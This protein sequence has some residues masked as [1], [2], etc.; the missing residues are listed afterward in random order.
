M[1]K[2][3]GLY[4]ALFFINASLIA[5]TETKNITPFTNLLLKYERF[6]LS[7]KGSLF[8]QGST[9]KGVGTD[10][11]YQFF[12]YD[13][14]A[15][16]NITPPVTYGL[17]DLADISSSL[18]SVFYIL[19][20]ANNTFEKNTAFSWSRRW[21]WS[22]LQA[23]KAGVAT[24]MV[25]DRDQRCVILG[26]IYAS[27]P[28]Y[29]AKLVTTDTWEPLIHKN[30]PA[31]L[32][33][34][35][36][37][38]T[39]TKALVDRKNNIYIS[40][41]NTKEDK[42]ILATW[43]GK[44]WKLISDLLPGAM[45]DMVLD[46]DAN[47]YVSGSSKNE[48]NE[49]YI[50]KW[51]G[52]KWSFIPAPPEAKFKGDM[53]RTLAIGDN[54]ELLTGGR[55]KKE[56][57]NIILKWNGNDWEEYG[58]VPGFVNAMSF[59]NGQ[60]FA[61]V[62]GKEAG[63]YLVPEGG[64][65]TAASTEA[66]AA[67]MDKK[68]QEVLDLYTAY[69][70]QYPQAIAKLPAMIK[71]WRNQATRTSSLEQSTK[72]GTEVMHILG[73]IYTFASKL[74]DLKLGDGDNKLHGALKSAVTAEMYAF[75]NLK[76]LM[77]LYQNQYTNDTEFDKWWKGYE[78][79]ENKAVLAFKKATDLIPL[80]EKENGVKQI[81]YEGSKEDYRAFCEAF[82]KVAKE[83]QAYYSIKFYAMGQG[84][85]NTPVSY[86][87]DQNIP[88]SILNKVQKADG[89]ITWSAL[90]NGNKDELLGKKAFLDVVKK[91]EGCDVVIG[92][93]KRS[94]SET[95]G[96]TITTWVPLELKRD[97]R[98]SHKD[99]FMQLGYAEGLVV[100]AIRWVK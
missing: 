84:T 69:A 13:G 68:V 12:N 44:Q 93:L 21:G 39:I 89:K 6:T 71:T 48:N 40:L 52:K 60:I 88:G 31:D 77:G 85:S 37:T 19:T 65:I 23:H 10:R 3:P 32:K 15:W 70:A 80:Y 91:I 87:T 24:A 8:L 22:N 11:S 58:A 96:N 95:D 14:T 72:V 20:R 43:T 1:I 56:R 16:S 75:E 51:D 9:D 74:Y 33:D 7:G 26:K 94:T 45:Y 41:S 30:M 66:P 38:Y 67:Q 27:A 49:Y 36:D 99:F 4:V 46:K 78:A 97:Y 28:C 29:A 25:I 35:F 34:I 79:D 5:Q 2:K 42:Y 100:L 54:N 62:E 17:T 92:S 63:I 73:Y 18:D 82:N 76:R 53:N 55:H 64:K 57:E 90:F 47:L 98:S 81:Q 61:A 83:S 59:K 50:S 86:P